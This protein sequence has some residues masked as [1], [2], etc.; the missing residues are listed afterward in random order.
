MTITDVAITPNP[1][2]PSPAS[3]SPLL[4]RVVNCRFPPHNIY[5]Y[6][7]TKTTALGPVMVATVAKASCVDDTG[8]WLSAEVIDENNYSPRRK[9]PRDDSGAPDHGALQR[10]RYAAFIGLSCGM[11]SSAPRCLELIRAY[12]SMPEEIRPERI[13]VGGWHAMDNPTPFLEAG[14]DVVVRGEAE[15]M[16]GTLLT[17]LRDGHS[18]ENISGISYRRG[19]EILSNPGEAQVPQE[20]MD[21]LPDPDFALVRYANIKIFPVGRTRGCDGRCRFCRVKSGARW[22]SPQRFLEQL[23]VL[24]SKGARRFFVI[25]DRSE[26]DLPGFEHWLR[27]LA[28]IK[29]DRKLRLDLTT[30]NRLSLA[31]RPEV[32][33]LMRQAGVKTVAIGFESP[34]PAELR[35]M[36]KPLKPS[37]MLE[38]SRE[39]KRHGFFVHMMLIFGYP[40][41][42]HARDHAGEGAQLLRMSARERA[43]HFRRFIRRVRPD[44]LQALLYTPLPGTE[45]REF[46]EQ[47]GRIYPF[48]WEYY[49]GTWLLFE[50]DE[51]AEPAELQREA[52]NL[53]RA[54]YAF[55]W[56]WRF[57]TTSLVLHLARI[58]L[59]TISLPLAWPIVGWGRW[60]RLWRDSKRRFQGHLVVLAW[61][62][63]FRKTGFERRLAAV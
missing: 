3:C 1:R 23:I 28:E 7:A 2:S 52:I 51:G 54:F 48:G 26:Q 5:R 44:T 9:G 36:R 30:Q 47:E 50:P 29:K 21:R 14:A 45:D 62:K 6:Q 57:K 12:R 15:P 35:A 24:S 33:E 43:R 19:T 42:P 53:M 13:I 56:L 11:T 38:W 40:L 18:L 59:V 55:P 17:A 27:G 60:H 58:G 34:I 16:I 39:W 46:L 63:N 37:K 41:P 20:M 25:D 10:E 8:P 49:D 31:E 22:I 32:L 4:L 61:L